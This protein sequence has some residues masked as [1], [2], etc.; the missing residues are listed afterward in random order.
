MTTSHIHRRM[1]AAVP[2]GQAWPCS[3]P[4]THLGRGETA[5]LWERCHQGA[6]AGMSQEGGREGERGLGP[7]MLPEEGRWTLPG[8]P[9]QALL[10]N[11][12]LL[13]SVRNLLS[14][15]SF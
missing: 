5:G 9:C 1:S 14:C 6:A 7:V 8:A 10:A 2:W 12:M 3:P 11:S 15:L 13:F 4:G